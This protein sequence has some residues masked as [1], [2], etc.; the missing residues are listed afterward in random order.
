M[1]RIVLALLAAVPLAAQ[2]PAQDSRNTDLPGTNT[3]FRMPVYRTLAEW[4]ARKA[5]LRKQILSAAGLLPMPE[6]TPLHPQVF[7]R[8]ENKDYSIEKVLLET[9]PG[10]YL[11]GNLYRPLGKPGRL[12]GIVSPHGHWNYG[13]LEHQPLGSIPARCISLARQGHVVFAYDMV[14]V[15]DTIQTPHRFGTPRQQL[16]AFGPLGLQTWNSIRA[17]DFMQSLPDVDPDRIAATGASGGGTQTF[18]LT[19]VDDRVKYS[20]PVNMISG[21]MQ[22][23]CDC[24]NAPNLRLGCNNME[25]GAMMAPRPLMMVSATGDWTRNTP[26]EEFPAIQSIYQLYGKPGDVETVLID[27]PHNYNQAS[28]EAV[29]RFF[30]KRILGDADASKFRER[31]IR[32]EYLQD[33]LALHNRTLPP[34]ALTYQQVFEEW[35][36]IAKAQNA[37]PGGKDAVR[38][39]LALALAA[40]WP[41]KVVSEGQ[42]EH[43]VLGRPGVGDR[44]PAIYVPGKG[45]PALVLHREGAEA[46][47]RSPEAQAL[48]RSGVPVLF[49]DAFQT[50]SAVAPR[51]Q[52]APH[53]LTFNKTDDAN[54]VQ[55][56]LTALAFLNRPGVKLVGL[57]KA[58]VWCTFAAAVAK[59]PVVLQADLGGFRGEDQDF[60][61]SF[62][63]PCI[64]RAGGLKAALAVAR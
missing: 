63:V 48:L 16:W 46:A 23:G 5:Q 54:R 7:G 52:S 21:I 13:R 28:R 19:A 47:R 33:M 30:G 36:A 15:N 31:N 39:R 26:R 12:P 29:Y 22:G 50:G 51:D 34:G 10:Y 64:Q 35:I 56:I 41:A 42:G 62:F 6:K 2:I 57:G 37:A 38:E 1:A 32:V 44:I 43:M 49:I 17:V 58:A 14:G 20:A 8:I 18:I 11:G 3:H 25:I 60:I 55:D 61:D 24:E 53:F 45:T 9:L 40:E 27:A 4:E 59:T